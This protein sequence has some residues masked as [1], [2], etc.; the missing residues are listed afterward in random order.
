MFYLYY[1][2]S[3]TCHLAAVCNSH[4][5]E[6]VVRYCSDLACAARAVVVIAVRVRVWHRIRIVRIQIITAFGRLRQRH[7]L[8]NEHFVTSTKENREMKYRQAHI[9]GLKVLQCVLQA[10][11]HY[12]HG[13]AF[14]GDVMLPHAGHVDVHAVPHIVVL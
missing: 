4:S 7:G 6:A 13:D 9:V 5:A 11:V 1:V 14:A 8:M 12:D 2:S 3:P 10:V